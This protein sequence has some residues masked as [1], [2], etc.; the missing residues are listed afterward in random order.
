[1]IPFLLGAYGKG[2]FAGLEVLQYIAKIELFYYSCWGMLI[3]FAPS[4]FITIAVQV[5]HKGKEN[6]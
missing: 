4:T 2:F 1:M 5:M 6:G 3:A